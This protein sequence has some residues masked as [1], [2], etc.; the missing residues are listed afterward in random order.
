MFSNSG[1]WRLTK[2]LFV[3]LLTKESLQLAFLVLVCSFVGQSQQQPS[4]ISDTIEMS[5]IE[6]TAERAPLIYSRQARVVSVITKEQIQAS[7]AK[8]IQEL[9]EYALN[10]DVRTRGGNDIQADVSIRGGSFDQTLILLN[11]IN[12]TNPQT[13]H[14]N[15]NLPVDLDAI[16]R[17]EILHGPAARVFGTNAFSG[18][19]NFITGTKDENNTTAFVSYGD[20]NLLKSGASLTLNTVKVKNFVSLSYKQSDGYVENTDF[21]GVNAFYQGIIDLGN[22]KL[23]VQGG[24]ST[25]DFGAMSFYTPEYPNQY[26]ENKSTFASA[27]YQYL[28]KKIKVT[29]SVYYRRHDDRFLLF[30]DRPDDY[31]NFHQTEV[32][33]AKIN[34]LAYSKLGKTTCG[35]EY[36]REL[37]RSNILGKTTSE[38]K[39]VPGYEGYFY[40]HKYDRY[41]ANFYFDHNVL[42]KGLSVALG[43]MVHH[44]SDLEALEVYPG[45]DLS[46]Q[47]DK[48]LRVFTS[49]N[50]SMR[51]PTFTDLFYMSPTHFGNALL[52]PEKSLTYELGIKFGDEYLKGHIAYYHRRGK[53]IIDWVLLSSEIQ[54]W[55]SMNIAELITNGLEYSTQIDFSKMEGLNKYVQSFGVNYNYNN[56]ERASEDYESQYALDNLKHKF[57]FN[58]NHIIYGSLKA[59]WKGVLQDRNGSY[60]EYEEDKKNVGVSKINHV[61]YEPFFVMDGRIFWERPLYT[62][63]FEASNIFGADYFDIGN[64]PQPGRWIRIGAKVNFDF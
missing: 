49:L 16:E 5:P 22:D 23:D 35:L 32:A 21:N 40:D 1:I 47:L 34:A 55:N 3:E 13:G 48:N 31:Q 24:Y 44:N 57:T 26:E 11:G 20:H 38:V 8:S 45:I 37:I 52:K 60:E 25:K 59:S 27:R 30:R 58:L 56:I 43:M 19:I 12:M 9:L 7:P 28:S 2:V 17:I 53:D 51:L 6:I 42:Y 36:R 4:V 10:V 50:R 15:L 64:V 29:P 33:G 18:A 61:A 63:Y 14:F 54:I 46:Y 41:H 62:V 39:P